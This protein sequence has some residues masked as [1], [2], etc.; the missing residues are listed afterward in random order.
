MQINQSIL[1]ENQIMYPRVVTPHYPSLVRLKTKSGLLILSQF[2]QSQMGT[3]LQSGSITQ[4]PH[5]SRPL[6][7]VTNIRL[8]VPNNNF[9]GERLHSFRVK[10][11]MGL[12]RDYLTFS[13]LGMTVTLRRCLTVTIMRI[14]AVEPLQ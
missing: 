7:F 10:I 3:K 8:C 2:I 1:S 9:F 12:F 13:H 5:L 4:L 11:W 6:L 14:I